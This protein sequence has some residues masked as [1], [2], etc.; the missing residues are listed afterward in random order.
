MPRIRAESIVA[1]K[2]LTYAGI[3]DA[4][5]D[6][7]VRRGFAHTSLGEIADVAG[8]A[9]TTIYEYFSSKDGMLLA[10]IAD[11]VA[12]AIAHLVAIAPVDDDPVIVIQ[13]MLDQAITYAAEHHTIAIALLRAGRKL[14]EHA[15]EEMWTVLDPYQDLI[16]EICRRATAAGEFA[17]VDPEATSR[18]LSD[19]FLGGVDAVLRAEDP[20][21]AAPHVIATRSRF[22][23]GA[24]R[25]GA[26]DALLVAA[27][28][29]SG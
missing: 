16:S 17:G 2:R 13:G 10:V 26:E 18:I 20:V 3:V 25:I 6:V 1:H 5:H 11:K 28:M 23:A 4:A 14:P 9:R 22:V 15:Q 7:F 27:E 19:I 24:L 21:A 29:K 8:I 12:P